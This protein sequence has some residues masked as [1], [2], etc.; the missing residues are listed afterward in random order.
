MKR[1]V[2]MVARLKATTRAM[3][4][5]DREAEVS[6]VVGELWLG[7]TGVMFLPVTAV[8]AGMANEAVT[9]ALPESRRRVRRR[10]NPR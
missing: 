2:A 7:V 6:G 10:A 9:A 3:E 5:R 4:C 8:W 1:A